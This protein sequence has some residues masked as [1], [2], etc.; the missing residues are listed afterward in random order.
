MKT[1]T[2]DHFIKKLPSSCNSLFMMQG[3]WESIPGWIQWVWE[4]RDDNWF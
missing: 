4:I 3:H 1:K 2:K